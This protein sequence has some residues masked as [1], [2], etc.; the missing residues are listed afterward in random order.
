MHT[1]K[2][3]LQAIGA[4]LMALR[5]ILATAMQDIDH[6]LALLQKAATGFAG[7]VDELCDH[8]LAECVPEGERA[9]DVAVLVLRHQG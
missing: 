7:T 6:G 2:P 3:Y 1:S 9:D 5:A 4:S 8:V